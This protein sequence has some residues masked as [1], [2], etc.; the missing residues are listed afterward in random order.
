ML[1]VLRSPYIAHC[2]S[3]C[4]PSV[5]QVALFY[6]CGRS[7]VTINRLA[8]LLRNQRNL[9]ISYSL[10]HVLSSEFRNKIWKKKKMNDANHIERHL[11]KE[12]FHIRNVRPIFASSLRIFTIFSFLNKSADAAHAHAFMHINVFF[13]FR[14]YS[15]S[16]SKPVASGDAFRKIGYA[17][18]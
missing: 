14:K 1:Q 15:K 17:K 10:L 2:H 8:L 4:T 11:N 9:R 5:K 12:H 7:E 13:F 16:R 3:S 18:S 6:R